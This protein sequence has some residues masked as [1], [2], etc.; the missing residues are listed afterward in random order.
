ML[1]LD[2]LFISQEVIDYLEQSHE[3]VLDNATARTLVSRGCRLTIAP[4]AEHPT[5]ERVVALSE[6]NLND[7]KPYCYP[8]V[9]RAIDL[10][11]DKASMR[12]A[13]APLYPT[14][15][16]REATLDELQRIDPS[17][18]DLPLVLKPATGFFSLGIYPIFTADEWYAAL[19]DIERQAPSWARLYNESVVNDAKFILESYLD[20]QEYALEAYFDENGKAVVL[21]ILKHDFAGTSDTSDRLYYTS[22]R[23][24]EEQLEPMTRFLDDCNELL[25]FRNFPVHPEVRVQADG[26]ITPI[27]FNPCRFAGLCGTDLAY[28]AWGF[29]TYAAFLENRRPDWGKILADKDGLVY[30]MILLTK[31]VARPCRFDYDA[32]K[33]RFSH[34]LALRPTDVARYHSFGFLFLEVPEERWDE[35]SSP[36]SPTIWRSTSP[37]SRVSE[38]VVLLRCGAVPPR[39]RALQ[40][41]SRCRRRRTRVLP[42]PAHK[43]RPLTSSGLS[44]SVGFTP[45]YLA[46]TH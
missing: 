38:H 36:S 2:D 35:E 39:S 10:C 34:V 42:S 1:V 14:Y 7:A 37:T 43:K 30:P 29:K 12:R 32:L 3:P 22:K 44:H 46:R 16:F 27:E 41:P 20:G 15:E 6:L 9:R 33:R 45:R 40:H 21:D 31:S 18:L 11:K 23:I 17:A 25:G 5:P 8:E 4:R 24:I 19:A 13:L 26:T 28:F